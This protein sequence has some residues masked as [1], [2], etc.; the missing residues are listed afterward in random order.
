MFY[1]SIF[2]IPYEVALNDLLL[3]DKLI[4]DYYNARYYIYVWLTKIKKLFTNL[5][6]IK[7]CVYIW[8]D[9]IR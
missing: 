7:H 1:N 3:C 8:I 4:I 2:Y 5:Y 6:I 9:F